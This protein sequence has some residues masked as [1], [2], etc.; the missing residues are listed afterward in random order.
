MAWSRSYQRTT[1]PQPYDNVLWCR[2]CGLEVHVVRAG[3]YEPLVVSEQAC[4]AHLREHHR[5]RYW[6]WRRLGWS[7]LVAGLA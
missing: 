1:E 5:L 7:W 2:M 4:A 6:L 3:S